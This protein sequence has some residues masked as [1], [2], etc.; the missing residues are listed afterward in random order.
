MIQSVFD[1][2]VLVSGSIASNGAIPGLLL[3]LGKGEYS[4]FISQ[5]IY[6]ELERT[7]RK[8]Y[9]IQRV[10]PETIESYLFM[11]LGQT[12]WIGITT[13]IYGA[14]SH[15]EDDLILATAVS[16]GAGYLVTG[17]RML[18]ELGMFRGVKIVSPGE[19]LDILNLNRERE[20]PPERP[21][22]DR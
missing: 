7:L 20:S 22:F 18:Q 16:A 1:T 11:L 6:A 3:A 15:P 2:N 9:F 8:P 12:I 14:A 13:D 21:D 5:P 17:D 4:L 10:S 19:F